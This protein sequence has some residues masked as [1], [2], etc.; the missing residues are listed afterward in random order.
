[1]S[2][3]SIASISLGDKIAWTANGD[4]STPALAISDVPAPASTGFPADY[5]RGRQ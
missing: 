3:A 2:T 4:T 5:D 1:M